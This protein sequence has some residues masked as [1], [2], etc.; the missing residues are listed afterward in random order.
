VSDDESVA[1][2]AIAAFVDEDGESDTDEVIVASSHPFGLG[3]ADLP[4]G[5]RHVADA[6]LP[7]ADRFTPRSPGPGADSPAM[8]TAAGVVTVGELITRAGRSAAAIGEHGGVLLST[9]VPDL[10]DG[11]CAGALA[12]W[13]AGGTLVQ[14]GPDS[15]ADRAALARIAA[16]E[17]AGLTLGVDVDGL[18]RVG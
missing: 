3:A 14:V 15:A 2:A 5:Y 11:V 18:P 8:L 9:A 7:Q 17:H 13:A 12:A 10:P 6:V 1:G 4:V 16:D